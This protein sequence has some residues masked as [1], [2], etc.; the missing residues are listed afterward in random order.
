MTI[1]IKPK[2]PDAA[3]I[4]FPNG[5]WPALMVETPA[6]EVVESYYKTEKKDIIVYEHP[7]FVGGWFSKEDAKTIFDLLTAYIETPEYAQ[8]RYFGTRQ[9][10]MIQF[11]EF[12]P[13]C[14]GFK[15]F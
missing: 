4:N 6:S 7:G 15:M 1:A 14:D 9:N 13:E 10:Q 3:T 5:F 11:L 12:L 2:N 8:H